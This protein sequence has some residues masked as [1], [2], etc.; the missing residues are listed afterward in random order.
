M[1][2]FTGAKVRLKTKAITLIPE[3]PSVAYFRNTMTTGSY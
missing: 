3:R 1:I 2:Q